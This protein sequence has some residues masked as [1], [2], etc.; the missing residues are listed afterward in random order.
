MADL[1]RRE[2]PVKP[3]ALVPIPISRPRLRERGYNQAELLAKAIGQSCGLPVCP[4]LHRQPGEHQVGKTRAEREALSQE[5]FFLK[6]RLPDNGRIVLVDDVITTGATLR[7]AANL[8][9]SAGYTP[10]AAALIAFEP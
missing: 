8:L 7:T 6:G 9:K 3:D 2:L 1:L 10:I 4:I 5:A